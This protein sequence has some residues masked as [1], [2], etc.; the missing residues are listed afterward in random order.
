MIK[1]SKDYKKIIPELHEQN[2]SSNQIDII[3]TLTEIK[4]KII[5][6]KD[7]ALYFY[8]K[9]FDMVEKDYQIQVTP[10]EIQDAY[11]CVSQ[12]YLAALKRAKQNIEDFH[13]NQIPQD[14]FIEKQPGI[15]YG[16]KYTP[17]E[18]AGLYVPGGRAPY[19]SSVLMDAIPAKIA[20][21]GNMVM[22]TPPQKDGTIAPQILVAADIC[23]ITNIVKA[24]GA[25]AVF[26]LA[27]GTESVDKVDKIVGPGNIYVTQ[28]KQMVYGRVDIDKP[29]GPSEALIYIDD[30][31]YIKFAAAELLSQ[32]E[33]D[34]NA[35]AVGVSS[36][37][38]ILRAIQK[39]L[40]IQI[41][42]CD[43][44]EIIQESAKN[45][46]LF[47][48]KDKEESISIINQVASEHLVLL[49]DDYK[50]LEPQIKN[51]GAIFLGPYTPVAL[52]DYYAGPN[53]VLPTNGTA[54]FASPLGVQDF[55]K[56]TSLLHY[57][58]DQLAKA[59]KD[60]EI[61][62]KMENFDAHYKSV[63]IRLKK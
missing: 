28:A 20:G 35:Q 15:K 16:L 10:T 60:L 27:F 21:V 4:D 37:E 47:L 7:K 41:A 62:T 23:G 44:Q 36:D 52:G 61:L 30:I 46:V 48:A 43:R 34:P 5:L 42:N 32:L 49:S 1:I 57:S 53:H 45:S 31:K 51:A 58:K 22:A 54:K 50:T 17:L 6:E 59:Q 40:L 26:A 9:K 8:T 63:E 33:H 11:K 55:V 13:Q 25:Q 2:Q 19:P 24:G 3:K 56:A 39:E 12:E 18:S 14:W 29:A 38:Q